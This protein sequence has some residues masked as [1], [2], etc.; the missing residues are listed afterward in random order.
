MRKKGF[1]RRVEIAAALF[2]A[3]MFMFVFVPNA[4]AQRVGCVPS[5]TNFITAHGFCD[6][7]TDILF[8]PPGD[9]LSLAGPQ[10]IIFNH[11]SPFSY[12]SDTMLFQVQSNGGSREDFGEFGYLVNIGAYVDSSGKLMSEAAVFTCDGGPASFCVQGSTGEVLLKGQIKGFAYVWNNGTQ[13]DPFDPVHPYD[14]FAFYVKLTG[15]SRKSVYGDFMAVTVRG[16]V[17]DGMGRAF[18]GTFTQP[19]DD[20]TCDVMNP[21]GSF[22]SLPNCSFGGGVLGVM[23]ASTQVGM[24]LD[25]CNGQISGTVVNGLLN[26]PIAGNQISLAG[27]DLVTNESRTSAANGSYAFTSTGAH[28]TGLCAGTYSVNSDVPDGFAP[29]DLYPTTRSVTLVVDGSG[30]DVPSVA[31]SNV[32]N[33][34]FYPVI[35]SDFKTWG[36]GGWGAKPNGFNAGWLIQNYYTAPYGSN[37]LVIGSVPA[38]RYV[39]LSGPTAVQNF[40][41]QGGKPAALD[42]AY[43]DPGPKKPT[44]KLGTLAGETL[45]LKLN[46]D[47]S[48]SGLTKIGLGS[49]FVGSGPLA[50]CSVNQVLT[51]ADSL[52]GGGALKAGIK[53]ED[54]TDTAGKI[55]GNYEG[56]KSKGYLKTTAGG[57]CAVQ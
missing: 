51:Y 37:P 7:F 3:A 12:N 14:D 41:P 36:Q 27:G 2:A 18:N 11:S 43:A 46:V 13:F 55:N 30:N 29:G 17:I 44:N 15:G 48:A 1:P 23:G 26:S 28:A 35:S 45:A 31:G 33:F 56:G 39:S 10:R 49:L 32:V 52:L 57:S 5:E 42:G 16:F 22:G 4:S 21:N 47:F 24:L 9:I 53:P 34:V 50:N 20:T 54:A 38:N 6:G 25:A 40:L 19:A 8:T